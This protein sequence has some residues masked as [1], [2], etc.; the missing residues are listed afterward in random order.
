MWKQESS[1]EKIFNFG[2]YLFSGNRSTRLTQQPRKKTKY[3][4]VETEGLL[5]YAFTVSLYFWSHAGSEVTFL[6]SSWSLDTTST[7]LVTTCQGRIFSLQ[8]S[9]FHSVP[10]KNYKLRELSGH[11]FVCSFTEVDEKV[12]GETKSSDHFHSTR[13]TTERTFSFSSSHA[14]FSFLSLTIQSNF[15]FRCSLFSIHPTVTWNEC[16]F[17]RLERMQREQ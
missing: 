6:V 14:L 8:F 11:I 9:L 16:P 5:T 17:V 4:W 7:Y 13:N 3:R 12:L 10:F 2:Q 1:T 15:L